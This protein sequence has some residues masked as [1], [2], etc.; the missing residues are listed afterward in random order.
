ME[1][2]FAPIIDGNMDSPDSAFQ[3]IYDYL[4]V[5]SIVKNWELLSLL[6]ST[7]YKYQRKSF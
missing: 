3:L 5:R 6:S 4:Q 1:K 2:S 7:A